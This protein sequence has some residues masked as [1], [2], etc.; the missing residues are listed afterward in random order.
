MVASVDKI[1]GF[2]EIPYF[3]PFDGRS[4][5][6]RNL[7]AEVGK[8]RECHIVA[9]V[10]NRTHTDFSHVFPVEPYLR[11][12]EVRGDFHMVRASG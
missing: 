4:A 2:S 3:Y 10:A 9:P 5:F 8:Y 12:S 6:L 11:V 7:N 1:S